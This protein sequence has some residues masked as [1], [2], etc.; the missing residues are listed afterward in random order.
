MN[1]DKILEISLLESQI[2]QTTEN[3]SKA[4]KDL[5]ALKR[6]AKKDL[7]AIEITSLNIDVQSVNAFSNAYIEHERS[8]FEG[9]SV[10]DA[11]NKNA[12]LSAVID[13][14]TAVINKLK[15]VLGKSLNISVFSSVLDN[16]EIPYNFDVDENNKIVFFEIENDVLNKNVNLISENDFIKSAYI[17]FFE[18]QNLPITA[19][20]EQFLKNWNNNKEVLSKELKKKTNE[21]KEAKNAFSF[22][23][24]EYK[25]TDKGVQKI[26][27]SRKSDVK[28]FESEIQRQIRL[29]ES[30]IKQKVEFLNDYKAELK[31][32]QPTPKK[33]A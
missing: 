13:R 12:S 28:P 23:K 5:T 10:N 9:F 16:F 18:I 22:L 14:K 30:D 17:P 11:E 8:F 15:F 4:K 33:E 24:R 31:K 2:K 26:G 29:I 7:E 19:K 21:I 20:Q 27:E 1:N 6:S 3:I 25:F 32:I